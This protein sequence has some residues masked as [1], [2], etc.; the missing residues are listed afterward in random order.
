MLRIK[1]VTSE[2]FLFMHH[3]FQRA[4]R[5]YVGCGDIKKIGLSREC[6]EGRYKYVI[7]HRR[8]DGDLAV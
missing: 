2:N 4:Q 8:L 1:V 3:E 6:V 7:G 5:K